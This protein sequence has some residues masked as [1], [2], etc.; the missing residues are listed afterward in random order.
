MANDDP[1]CIAF[2]L[3][4]NIGSNSRVPTLFLDDYEVWVLHMEDYISGIDKFGPHVWRS[5][6]IGPHT[7]YKMK[8]QV[9]SIA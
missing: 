5:M 1:H 9:T 2:N 7:F 3:D 6:T 4:S 8:S